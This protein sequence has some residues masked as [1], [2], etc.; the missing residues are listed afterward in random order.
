MRNISGQFR[1]IFLILFCV[2]CTSNNPEDLPEKRTRIPDDNFEQALIDLGYDDVPDDYV[3]TSEIIRITELSLGHYGKPEETK[4]ETLTGIED[5]TALSFLDVSYHSISEIDLTNNP[6]LWELN[7]ANNNLV[8]ID[9][10]KNRDLHLLRLDGNH[11]SEIDLS[12][13]RKLYNI[14]IVSNK[15]SAIDLEN[16]QDLEEIFLCHNE[17]AHLDLSGFSDLSI[18]WINDNDLEALDISNSSKLREIYMLNNMLKCVQV[19]ENQLSN[20][21]SLFIVEKDE[22]VILSSNCN[23]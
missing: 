15:L 23:S 9:L 19:D 21:S 12:A 8:T 18:V 17:I 7:L 20:N 13:N 11:F 22:G 4:I 1:L 3:L 10:S 14:S 5:F 16:N 2:S 6:D